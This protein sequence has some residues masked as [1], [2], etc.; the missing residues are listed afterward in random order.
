MGRF[1]DDRLEEIYYYGDTDGVLAADCAIIQRKLHIL[2]AIQ[3]WT[4]LPLVGK[5]LPAGAGRT[6]I[7]ATGSWRI[8]FDWYE[9]AGAAGLRLEP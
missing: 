3:G 5:P 2:N 6:G 1:D 4:T 8:T 9:G 7:A